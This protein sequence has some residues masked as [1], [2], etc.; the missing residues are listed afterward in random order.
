MG[1]STLVLK[2]ITTGFCPLFA[3]QPRSRDPF[4]MISRVHPTYPR[5][6]ELDLACHRPDQGEPLGESNGAASWGVIDIFGDCACD[7]VRGAERCL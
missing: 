2:T 7:F 4:G 3:A 5:L 1:L 6:A